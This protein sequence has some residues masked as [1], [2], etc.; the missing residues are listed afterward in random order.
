LE[1]ALFLARIFGQPDLRMDD[2]PEILAA[3]DT[4]RRPRACRVRQTSWE[5]GELYEFRD[6]HV[7]DDLGRL[8]DLLKARY[9]WIWKHD[10]DAEVARGQELVTSK[11]RS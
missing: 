11:L 1:D 6:P 9:D 10:L 3:F 4:I 5:A 2:L 7:G 8:A